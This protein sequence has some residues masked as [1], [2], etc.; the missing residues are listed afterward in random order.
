[1]SRTRTFR[2]LTITAVLSGTALPGCDSLVSGK[3]EGES[4][5]ALKVSVENG[6]RVATDPLEPALGYM[7]GDAL[8]FD[9]VEV[10][11]EFPAEFRV[12]VYSAPK[13]RLLT[14]LDPLLAPKTRLAIQFLG[15]IPK[16]RRDLVI[17]LAP[18]EAPENEV[19]WDGSCDVQ[20]GQPVNCR[21]GSDHPECER[22]QRECAGDDCESSVELE[23]PALPEGLEDIVGFSV[24]HVVLYL[25]DALPAQSWAALRLGAPDGLAA[26]YH[27]AELREPDE[28]ALSAASKCAGR[29]REA[30]LEAF[31]AER[32]VP[33]D[34]QTMRCLLSEEAACDLRAIP[35]GD[36]AQEL[37]ARVAQA[38]T[39]ARCALLAIDM[40]PVDPETETITVR[41]GDTAPEWSPMR[42]STPSD[43]A[44]DEP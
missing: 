24:G 38:E 40:A 25:R 34:V 2:F 22:V 35:T 37:G 39:E 11:G 36:D 5:L 41:I 29:A 4:R 42:P 18:K 12:D 26:G 6:R 28:A 44:A 31:N 15:A 8:R 23:G 1:M 20:P 9:R 30:A 33:L 32:D 21:E 10:R 16:H 7:D 43:V 17:D 27:L 3:Y 13:G 14:P 19:C